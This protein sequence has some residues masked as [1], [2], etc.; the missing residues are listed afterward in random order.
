[1]KNNLL[2][3]IKKFVINHK[4]L[5]FLCILLIFIVLYNLDYKFSN[6]NSDNNLEDN[7]E[8]DSFSN[9]DELHWAH[10]PLT[11]NITNKE[12]CEDYELKNILD[13]FEIIENSTSGIVNFI[14][15][16]NN[17]DIVLRCINVEKELKKA[18]ICK[19]VIFDYKKSNFSAYEE[20]GINMSSQLFRST[21]VI[22]QGDN[23]TIYNVCY[24]NQDDL[25]FHATYDSIQGT[26]LGEALPNYEGNKIINA[27]LWIYHRDSR[28]A[29]FP[30]TEVHEL[31]HDFGFG[32]SYEPFFDP[33]YGYADKDA[34]YLMDI[35]FPY[36]SCSLQKEIQDKYISCLKYIYSNG[37]FYGSCSDVN[38]LGMEYSC[39]DG[40]HV[41]EGT[42]FCCPEPGMRIIE[43][44]CSY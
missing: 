31:L 13:S 6:N 34:I 22:E 8:K 40:W 11:Y 1:M 19:L 9:M 33:L 38:F 25:P 21:T 36:L 10:M 15:A 27:T 14:E 17:P 43:G 7:I 41:V 44:Y 26:L 16:E 39:K 32:H 4:W 42:N 18:E 29:F 30:V 28:C 37:Q 3:K 24:V 5:T 35:M 23:K 12:D 2:V 20:G